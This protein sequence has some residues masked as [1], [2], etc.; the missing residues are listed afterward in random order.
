MKIYK[1]VKSNFSGISHSAENF[2][3]LTTKGGQW[4]WL[5]WLSGRF[6]HK[7]SAVQ[8]PTSAKFYIPIVH[9]NRKN[10]IKKRVRKWPIFE[11]T[12]FKG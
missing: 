8:I 12:E 5:S 9:L 1:L 4:W 11:K 7:R 3:R 10:E 2:K 6:R